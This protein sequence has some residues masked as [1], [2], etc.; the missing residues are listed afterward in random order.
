MMHARNHV[1]TPPRIIGIQAWVGENQWQIDGYPP[2]FRC[3]VDVGARVAGFP[4]QRWITSGRLWVWKDVHDDMRDQSES[5][6]NDVDCH[7][8]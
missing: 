6:S 3:A 8:G 2:T 4:L 5:G 7:C 1:V